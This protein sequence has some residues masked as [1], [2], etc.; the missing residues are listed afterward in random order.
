MSNHDE[1]IY[2][3][4]VWY[5]ALAAYTFPT[6]FVKLT[7]PEIEALAHGVTCGEQVKEIVRRMKQPMHM[8]PGNCFA[9]VDTVA[10]T[11]TSR[12]KAK[13]GAV[14][15]A[16]SAWKFLA[17]SMKV[18]EAA[19]A[20]KVEY[21]CLRP[22][23]RMNNTREFRLFIYKGELR[24]MSQYNL[25]KHFRRLESMKEEYW[26]VAQKFMDRAGWLLPS[27][28]LV[29][30]IYITSDNQV[31][32]IDLNPW[33]EGTDPKMLNTWDRDWEEEIGI[34]LMPPPTRINGDVNVSF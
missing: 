30:D 16:S 12:F 23:R 3:A 26:D 18:R 29:V 9:F 31:L 8:L 22:F 1:N 14:H 13:R 15:S 7:Q 21:I 28:N 17:R 27:P 6:M 2:R 24:A 4:P 33:G 19:A 11:D 25:T 20:G 10:P 32:V 34:V 5:P